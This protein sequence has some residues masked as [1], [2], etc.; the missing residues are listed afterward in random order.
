MYCPCKTRTW[1]RGIFEQVSKQLPIQPHLPSWHDLHRGLAV[2]ALAV[3]TVRPPTPSQALTLPLVLRN[4]DEPPSG[5]GAG[6]GR[7]PAGGEGRVRARER[8]GTHLLL[9]FVIR[10]LTTHP[11]GDGARF[12][13]Q[14][15]TPPTFGRSF[16]VVHILPSFVVLLFS[17]SW[18][19][20]GGVRRDASE[21][22][23]R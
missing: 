15:E 9:A 6:E 10:P 23:K 17:P 3:T 11:F 13:L 18:R 5:P 21:E 7:Q 14:T 4:A 22:G 12:L 1:Y 8:G 19:R 2:G 20:G 16:R